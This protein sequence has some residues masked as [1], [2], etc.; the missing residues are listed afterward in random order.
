MSISD[1]LKEKYGNP[2]SA[3]FE[4]KNLS[5]YRYPEDVVKAL[6]CLGKSLYCHRDLWDT[7]IKTLRALIAKGLYKEINTNDQCFCIRDIRGY[8]GQLSTHSWAMAIDLNPSDNPLGLTRSQ[9]RAKGLHPFSEEFI[10]VWRDHGWRCGAD[11]KRS[12]LMHFELT[13]NL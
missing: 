12:D 7:Y 10:Q 1:K 2:K 13:L 4:Q 3:G 5:L 6:P 11:F 9:A 8:P